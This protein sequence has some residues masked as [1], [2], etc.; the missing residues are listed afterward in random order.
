MAYFMLLAVWPP[1]SSLTPDS[2]KLCDVTVECGGRVG[3]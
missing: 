2:E 3:A 1:K